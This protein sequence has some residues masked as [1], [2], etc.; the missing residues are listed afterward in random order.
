MSSRVMLWQHTLCYVFLATCV[1]SRAGIAEPST[2]SYVDSRFDFSLRFPADAVVTAAHRTLDSSPVYNY[3][4][5][6]QTP[7]VV[8]EL[9]PTSFKGTNLRSAGAYVA[10]SNDSNIVSICTKAAEGEQRASQPVKIAGVQFARFS[11]EDG[12]AGTLLHWTSQRALRG[13]T[14]YEIVE[15]LS[16]GNPSNYDP[17]AIKEFDKKAIEKQLRAIRQSFEFRR[18]SLTSTRN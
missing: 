14:C 5:I 17:G 8:I 18:R 3:D 4:P 16:W 1:F 15:W 6:T 9:N 11:V 2:R 12:G 13:N 7:A 10:L